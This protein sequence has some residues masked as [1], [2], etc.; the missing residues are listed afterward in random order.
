MCSSTYVLIDGICYK[1]TETVTTCNSKRYEDCLTCTG[2]N[3]VSGIDLSVCCPDNQ[4]YNPTTR[5]CEA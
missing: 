2:T 3:I 1:K 4:I 5:L